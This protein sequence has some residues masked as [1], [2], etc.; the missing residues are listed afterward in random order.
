MVRLLWRPWSTA[1]NELWTLACAPLHPIRCKSPGISHVELAWV[2]SWAFSLQP[3]ILRWFFCPST[4]WI[5]RHSSTLSFLSI[6]SGS[7]DKRPRCLCAPWR[8]C[9]SSRHEARFLSSGH[10]T[11]GHISHAPPSTSNRSSGCF[12]AHSRLRAGTEW[13][14]GLQAASLQALISCKAVCWWLSFDFGQYWGLNFGG[15][16]NFLKKENDFEMIWAYMSA[17]EIWI[18]KFVDA[19]ELTRQSKTSELFYRRSISPIPPELN[20]YKKLN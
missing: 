16:W 7:F 17:A 14:F 5:S 4:V 11:R 20:Y 12:S 8:F 15:F 18:F 6:A 9:A 10:R 2:Y 1:S 13:V 3:P 19:K